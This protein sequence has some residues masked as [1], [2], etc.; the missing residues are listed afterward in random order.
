MIRFL[1]YLNFLI[2]L[3]ERDKRIV[4]ALLIVFIVAFV[5]IAYIGNGIRALMRRYSKGIDSYM[6]KLCSAELVTNPR[7]FFAQVFK[8]ETKRLYFST[9]WVLRIFMVSFVLFYIYAASVQGDGPMFAFVGERLNDLKIIFEVPKGEF[10]GISNFPIDWPRIARGPQ[11]QFTLEGISTYLMFIVTV[12]TIFGITTST[13]KFIARLNRAK[14]KGAEVFT[15]S[16]DD[17]SFV[18]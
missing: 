12:A 13:M 2:K 10:F 3:T 5:L 6:H 17:A 15:K 8:K 1:P 18:K 11:P 9:R 7:Q 14:K 4:V 16:L